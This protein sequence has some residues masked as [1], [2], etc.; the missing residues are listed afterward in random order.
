MML[1]P[2]SLNTPPKMARHLS[3]CHNGNQLE[4]EKCNVLLVEPAMTPDQTGN[5]F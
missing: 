3:I 4:T 5:D 1:D 2:I